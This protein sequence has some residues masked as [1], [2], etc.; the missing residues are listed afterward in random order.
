MAEYNPAARLPEPPPDGTGD[1]PAPPAA[2]PAKRGRSRWRALWLLP[3]GAL[4]LTA[5]V[6][7]AVGLALWLWTQADTSLDSALRL[8]ARY[9]PAGQT[10]TAEGVRGALRDGGTIDR[11][12][13]QRGD[14]LTVTAR[15]IA[16]RWQPM[17]LL[18]Q[19]LRLDTLVI[20]ELEID[21]QRPPGNAPLTS[22]ELPVPVD[23]PF[24]IGTLLWRGPPAFEAT[25]LAGH[26]R[27]DRTR[28]TLRVDAVQIAAGRY[29]AKADLLAR[30]PMTLDLGV[31]GDLQAPVPGLAQPLPLAADATVRGTL[32]GADARLAIE[33]RLLPRLPATPN[34][35]ATPS[36]PMQATLSAQVAP[37]AA[38]PVLQANA[39]FHDVNL[40]ALWPGA[41][42]T[43]L[44]G[45]VQV[46]PLP[47]APGG[48]APPSPGNTAPP[49]AP[50]AT[51]VWGAETQITNR[52]PGPW[53]QHRLP[54][55]SLQARGALEAARVQIDALTADVAGGRLQA[56]GQWVRASR[57][58]ASGT[59]SATPTPRATGLPTG[60]QGEATLQR[61]NPAALHTQLLPAAVDGE[62]S[63]RAAPSG[64]ASNVSPGIAFDA[65]LRPSARQPAASRL[66]GLRLRAATA[67]GL[68]L[69][70]A[71]QR[72]R[73]QTLLIQTDDAA[74]QGQGEVQLAS[75]ASQGT[76]SL[77][78]PGAQADAQGQLSAAAG[79]GELT[80]R[81]ANAALATRW[82]AQ[83]PGADRWLAGQPL[84]GN[85]ELSGRWQGGW[86]RGGA[87]LQVQSRL[88][89]PLL[90]R[91]AP[92]DPAASAAAGSLPP[93]PAWRVRDL[94][95]EING[96]LSAM[97]G[98]LAGQLE[99]GTRR[100]RLQTQ[101][102]GGRITAPTR[103]VAG[104]PGTT[105]ASAPTWQARIPTATLTANDS[106]RP[107]TWTVQLR[108]PVAVLG[109][110][111][112]LSASAGE[113]SLTGPLPGAS[114]LAWQP[115]SFART[116]VA[117]GDRTTLRSS[118]R[119]SGL[120][121][122]WL[123]WLGDAQLANLGL[124]G[125]MVFDGDWDVQLAD[126]L[127]LKAN[128]ARRSGDLRVQA[129]DT[130]GNSL[131]VD[132][133]VKAA[134][135]SLS[136]EG[137]AVRL[138]LRWDSER[139]GQA[140]AEFSTQ[141]ERAEGGW[142]WP[143]D[144]PVSGT[145]EAN[146]PR[147]GVWSVLAPPGWRMRGTLDASAR[148][149][150]T[151]RSPQWSGTLN[152]NDLAIRSVVEGIEFSNGRL[153]TT[154]A[155]QRLEIR[156]FSL[157]GAPG[158]GGAA[159]GGTL[160]ATGFALWATDAGAGATGT[161]TRTPPSALSRLRIELAAQARSLRVSSRA[162]RRLVVSGDLQAR[163][164][165]ARLE[166]RGALKADSALFVLPEETAP[167]LGSDVVVRGGGRAVQ[168]GTVAAGTPTTA[169]TA[170]PSTSATST[171]SDPRGVRVQPD[172]AVTLNLGDDFQVQG[173]GL[174]TRLAGT[175]DLRSNA[176][177][178]FQPRLVGD[179]RT[180]RG[181]YKAYGQQLDIEEGLI[182]FNGPYDNPVLDILAVRPNLTVVVGVQITGT[183][184]SPR[185]RL[186]ADPEMADAD[187]LAWLVL[188]RA[189]ANG[190]AE[191]AVL[192]Q[193]ALALLGGNS[194][195]ISG[196]LAD[197]LGLDEL[198][199]RGTAT[200]SDGTTASAA[201]TLGKRLSRDFYVAYERSLAGTLGTF[202]I[203]YDLSRRFTLRAQ[204]G[205]Q[206]AIDLIFTVPF[207]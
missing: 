133:G 24:Q 61:I 78:L 160:N 193:A 30:A 33:A 124:S 200:K 167:T 70:G 11:L 32:A 81:V 127:R 117:A 164:A 44:A 50:G 146:L 116:R 139:A 14:G 66:Q 156:E 196:G 125:D 138:A 90:E 135:L 2:A 130:A 5:M 172:M 42:Q 183:A 192:Q 140:Q 169:S 123:D 107:G 9:L 168:R 205:E 182:R 34:A 35:R 74:L 21:D 175:L 91:A 143:M 110:G 121:L 120:P 105:P 60:W 79:A 92:R 38:Q 154:L 88:R 179:V 136:S 41:P 65:R 94:Q 87:E 180:V 76:L 199:F 71:S 54:V 68:W 119:L 162:D 166:L 46:R 106:L 157:A 58:A 108:Q 59:S 84:S 186:Y 67:K 113:A 53:N 26:Y 163:L 104:A 97:S 12:H 142:L 62:L 55:T 39:R 96:Q 25:A 137:D 18:Q 152:A 98:V 148:L 6:L 72:V 37:W 15:Q 102:E 3:L 31:N 203:F 128:L 19:Q 122:A 28:H 80:V 95:A 149:A 171:T 103:P 111:S 100:Y 207:D 188:G 174:T 134:N 27:Y 195:G 173:R 7:V 114:T 89:V 23:L 82:L 177:T 153:R 155:G 141:L 150:G 4:W 201:V 93:A 85:G 158:P 178:A 198:S 194:R 29:R 83:W 77:A 101:A 187:K 190:G 129:D 8:G 17:A 147:V 64:A 56:Q 73:L 181:S 176:G 145:L 43:L 75:G 189:A 109:S 10:L 131:R 184:L 45:M 159:S 197:A 69:G 112:T 202:Y 36:Q 144:A 52:L 132:A 49:P 47:N 161:T 20:G 40:A 1:A 170:T 204:T 191:S 51:P 99:S 206:S 63:A 13:W 16:L 48:A 86:Q 151:R 165:G 118:G 185:V 22:L 115:V 126:T 57:T